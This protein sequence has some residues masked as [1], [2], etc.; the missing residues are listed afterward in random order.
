MMSSTMSIQFGPTIIAAT[1]ADDNL[2]FKLQLAL[3]VF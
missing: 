1:T 3:S 2:S